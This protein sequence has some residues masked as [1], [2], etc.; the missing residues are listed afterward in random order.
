M[1]PK[2]KWGGIDNTLI[3]KM[4][5]SVS[6][7]D[8]KKMRKEHAESSKL[9]DDINEKTKKGIELNE[10][11]LKVLDEIL[12]KYGDLDVSMDDTLKLIIKVMEEQKMG[13]KEA[14]EWV[15]KWESLSIEVQGTLDLVQELN[16]TAGEYSQHFSTAAD[17]QNIIHAGLASIGTELVKNIDL[18]TRAG[19]VGVRMYTSMVDKSDEL[20][21]N[22]ENIG[23]EEFRSVDLSKEIAFARRVRDKATVAYLQ[24]LQ[25]INDEW[26]R[27][28][29]QVMAVADTIT[30]M[31]NSIDDFISRIPIIGTLLSK[32][33]D[34]QHIGKTLADEFTQG[35]TTAFG[36]IDKTKEA[37][38]KPEDREEQG[39]FNIGVDKTKE[40]IKEATEELSLMGMAGQIVGNVFSKL[41][42]IAKSVM[43]T[44]MSWGPAIL[45]II[46]AIGFATKLVFDFL[47]GVQ[48]IHKETGLTY[49]ASI[50]LHGAI[51]KVGMQ[52]ALLG[53]DVEEVKEGA[54]ALIQEW[55]SVGMAT[56]ENI[57][58]LAELSSNLGV[59]PADA[60]A[61]AVQMKAVGGYSF[62]A[63]MSQLDS[64][65][66]LAQ[67]AGV[68]P[69]DVMADLAE[70]TD[71]FA[72]FAQSGGKNLMDAAISARQLGINLG[73]VT[74]AAEDLLDWETSIEKQFEAQMLTGK[75]INTDLA[76]RLALEGN[77]SGLQA[78]ILRQVGNE[79]EWNNYNVIQRKAVAEAFG[80]STSELAKMIANQDKLNMRA[81]L[82]GLSAQE[83]EKLVKKVKKAWV[84]IV[85][86]VTDLWPFIV[87]IASPLI[88]VVTI[89]GAI[90]T[91]F[92][93]I[94]S[95]LEDVIGPSAKWFVGLLGAWVSWSLLFNKS[96][97]GPIKLIGQI[98]KFG[99]NI[100]R[101]LFARLG[102]NRQIEASLVTQG[103]LLS[104]LA[105]KMKKFLGFG[106]ERVMGSKG[107][108]VTTGGKAWQRDKDAGIGI[109]DK[110]KAAVNK[111][112]GGNQLS[113]SGVGGMKPKDMMKAAFAVVLLAGA[114]WIAAKAFQEFA[115]VEWPA[116]A[117]GL[118][119]IF[120][121][122]L[123]AKIMS[124]G[125]T[126]M[127]IGAAAIAILGVA[128]IPA[129]YAFSLLAGVDPKSMI[130]FAASL[131][132][133]A[134]GVFAFGFALSNP[135]GLA[136]F[137]AGIIGLSLL[138]IAIMVIG[139]A[140]QTLGK[141]LASVGAGFGQI[142]ED[143]SDFSQIK[144]MASI[145]SSF[146]DFTDELERMAEIN[147]TAGILEMLSG[148]SMFT[149]SP[150]LGPLEGDGGL[151]IPVERIDATTISTQTIN[152]EVDDNTGV[153]ALGTKIDDLH[154]MLKP[155]V[156]DIKKSRDHLGDLTR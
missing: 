52:Y 24:G 132:V 147:P 74:K 18:T 108:L 97:V 153:G 68:A 19:K 96:L 62:D 123:I 17:G 114:M 6:Q 59:L 124:K 150:S 144:D 60:A 20:L 51:K 131:I 15:G 93:Y 38:M 129:A 28:H 128:L 44:I 127:I 13:V 137:S 35:F 116:V 149:V 70:N 75:N 7:E 85:N 40:V 8:A 33:F 55:G 138:G 57:R 2:V 103:G 106:A 58:S 64:V 154:K 14:T 95:L 121:L 88:A 84:S 4:Q 10:D 90:V 11:L 148:A 135:I 49:L 120:G 32:V 133:L 101:N 122:M 107:R 45:G 92:G 117:L 86:V 104:G 39:D 87:G 48:D 83:Y 125:S 80:L 50:K 113:R 100:L 119:A 61:L 118:G 139:L 66:A 102:L 98:A 72:S 21:N 54:I 77:I 47:T 34:F 89:L 115:E 145:T 151:S 94:A 82:L 79:A 105:G 5:K 143:I 67:A 73:V 156:A 152:V 81:E 27:Q 37:V 111:K 155:I 30:N 43:S 91:G 3:F 109:F 12:N 136:L 69:A 41:N 141:G 126:N 56:E 31:F 130:N 146:S 112:G 23:T 71:T 99:I 46:V 1:N 22:I 134:A 65:G 142:I 16:K 29:E 63:A 36:E 110:T 26:S 140:F 25:T 42:K 78:E 9:V 53:V 76:R